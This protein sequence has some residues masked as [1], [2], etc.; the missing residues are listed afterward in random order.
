MQKI[1]ALLK[2]S[3][4]NSFVYKY[5][6]IGNFVWIIIRFTIIIFLFRSI[7]EIYSTNNTI[8]WY[9]FEFISWAMIFSQIV[10]F[11]NYRAD[12]EI[13]NEIKSWQISAFLLY[14]INYIFLK[15]LQHISSI[16]VNLFIY[17]V[18]GLIVWYFLIGSFPIN[19]FWWFLFWVIV[20]IL[21]ALV[22]YFAY[23][24]LWLVSF[25]TEDSEWFAYLYWKI[26]MLLSWNLIPIPFFPLWVQKILYS[27]PFVYT[28][29]TAWFVIVDFNLLQ[30]SKIILIQ[31]FWIIVFVLLCNI[32][33]NY[34]KK[35]LVI[36]GW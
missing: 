17:F 4:K 22:Y 30:A 7:F 21:S 24:F 15:F 12:N 6:V 32:M 10:N 1:L 16:I 36:N 19:S 9:S 3:L 29:Y 5:E 25:V 27:L 13:S 23:V 20:L 28:W 26:N 18:F 35:K 11:S 34:G 31:L 8:D 33:L 14:P 2:I